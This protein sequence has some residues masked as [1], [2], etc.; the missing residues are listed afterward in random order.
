[1]DNNS[2]SIGIDVSK[3]KLD[4]AVMASG[5]QKP[6]LEFQAENSA[7]CC[8]ELAIR[9]LPYVGS[10]TVIEAT[11]GY[12][13]ASAFALRDAGF[14][15]KVINPII[16]G[17]FASSGI[18]KTKTDR[19]D[20]LLLARIG[21]LEPDLADYT[22]NE[23]QIRLKQLSKAIAGLKDQHRSLKQKADHLKHLGGTGSAE[24]I[25][26]L[27][28]VM[29]TAEKETS[30]LTKA[31]AGLTAPEIKIISSIR[32]VGEETAAIIAAE[33]GDVGRFAGKRQ[34]VAFSGLDPSVRES[35]SSLKGKSRISKRGSNVLR[36]ALFRGAWGLMMH[37][38]RFKAFYEKK[39][40]EG[41]HYF[42]ILCAMARKL[43]ILIYTMLKNQTLYDP[44]K[45]T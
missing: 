29:K 17:K 18:R 7:A 2:F 36:Y 12:H 8:R 45:F 20:A 9:L 4:V 13:Y 40:A 16:T 25:R 6:V 33:L 34:A 39:R 1:M 3:A 42:A 32:G 22:E 24:I 26:A 10:V 44:I 37:N 43:L 38:P 41:K 19:T 15:V 5:S 11:A 28:G 27:E 23:K 14:R 30:K 35:G 21:I 31:L